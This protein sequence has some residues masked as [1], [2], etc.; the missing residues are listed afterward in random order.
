MLS[1]GTI[2]PGTSRL[3]NVSLYGGTA[4]LGLIGRHA[5]SRLGVSVAYGS[6]ED[7]VP[8][9]PSGVFD[10]QGYTRASVRQ[11]F[12]YCFLASTFRY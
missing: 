12:L 1:D 9:D 10:A 6:G 7:A 11:L 4:T 8:N 5:I 2:K 3:A